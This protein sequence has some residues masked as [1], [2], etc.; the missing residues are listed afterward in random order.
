[1]AK[2][3]SAK[4][5]PDAPS[6]VIGVRRST[7]E[8]APTLKWFNAEVYV[9]ME[10]MKTPPPMYWLQAKDRETAVEHSPAV[11]IEELDRWAALRA[12]HAEGVTTPFHHP[13]ST[14]S[15]NTWVNATGRTVFLVHATGKI[16][17]VEQVCVRDLC[18][19]FDGHPTP[20]ETFSTEEMILVEANDTSPP[21]TS[22]VRRRDVDELIY[23]KS[24]LFSSSRGKG[25]LT[26]KGEQSYGKK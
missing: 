22:V 15:V 16:E 5:T 9:G 1:M 17:K 10:V 23:G 8:E 13:D 14:M 3:K 18:L 21:F 26:I 6:L 19:L 12:S 7:V 20:I 24:L 11:F 25:E 2:R 4:L